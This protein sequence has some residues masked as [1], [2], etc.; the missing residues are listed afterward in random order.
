MCKV[1]KLFITLFGLFNEWGL[2]IWRTKDR[3]IGEE[4]D[5][6]VFVLRS[7]G[8]CCMACRLFI[9]WLEMKP[10]LPELGGYSLNHWTTR[11]VPKFTGFFYVHRTKEKLKWLD[12]RTYIPFL[13]KERAFEVQRKI[14]YGEVTRKFTEELVEG[15]GK[16]WRQKEQQQ[17]IR[18]LDSIID[19]MD[20]NLS[21]LREIVE[22]R[23]P[24]RAAVH[25]IAEMDP[26][27]DWP[28]PT[29]T[30]G[31]QCYFT[32]ACLRKLITVLTPSLWW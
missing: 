21:K 19:S 9:P 5:I 24:W 10:V 3:A 7:F 18:W 6:N 31:R 17:R 26:L 32:K 27:S 20:M 11:E 25:G 1:G 13:T 15:A 4:R 2:W 30:N 14:N 8:P 29:I 22:D 16:D 28:L 23:E 12:L